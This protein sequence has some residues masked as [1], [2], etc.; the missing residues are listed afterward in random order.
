MSRR[1]LNL[2]DLS[3]PCLNVI[4]HRGRPGDRVRACVLQT[5]GSERGR[6]TRIDQKIVPDS[7]IA[8]HPNVKDM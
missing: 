8:C 2:G 3:N 1:L 5:R 7:S 6:L 4:R